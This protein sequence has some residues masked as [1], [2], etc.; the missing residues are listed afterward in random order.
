MPKPKTNTGPCSIHDCKKESTEFRRLTENAMAKALAADT[1]KQYPYLKPDQ[2]I[3]LSHY[4]AI[5]ESIHSSHKQEEVPG[6]NE[7]QEDN[8]MIGKFA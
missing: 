3:C 1:L 5:V 2:Q 6:F 7:V 8:I 4:M